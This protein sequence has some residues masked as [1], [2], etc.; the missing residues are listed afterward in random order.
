MFRQIK[1]A[2]LLLIVLSVLTGIVYPLAITVLAQAIFPSQANGSLIYRDGR[3]VAST[4]IGQPFADPK[5]FWSRPSATSPMPYNAASSGGSNLGPTN[6]DLTRNVKERIAA[7]RAADPDRKKGTGPIRRNGPKGASHE[8]DL[9]PYS[10]DEAP[11]PID[12][13]TTSAS[14]LDPHITPAAAEYQVGRVAKARQLDPEIV[15]RLVAKH[16]EGRTLGLLGEPRVN[17]VEL[18][19]DLD[20]VGR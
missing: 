10:D 4:L 9:S 17:V 19:L 16:T 14:G 11:V 8:L 6:P 7:L 5:Y 12:L 18:N 13:V 1:Q 3:P 20:G 2:L 15:R